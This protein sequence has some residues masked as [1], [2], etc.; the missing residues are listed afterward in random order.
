MKKLLAL[1]LS[2]C[3]MVSIVA[4]SRR[5]STTS[6]LPRIESTSAMS[7]YPAKI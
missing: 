1:L 7:S 6:T 4:F 3:M 5:I 2:L